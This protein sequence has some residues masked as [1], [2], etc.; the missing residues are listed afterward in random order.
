MKALEYYTNNNT[1]KDD[2]K[3]A[4]H[5]WLMQFCCKK[6]IFSFHVTKWETLQNNRK[7][8]NKIHLI[9]CKYSLYD[10]ST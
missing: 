7:K 2:I 5:M 4:T 1:L 6:K 9:M 3:E 8:Y 10:S